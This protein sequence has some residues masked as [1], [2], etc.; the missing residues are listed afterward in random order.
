MQL[1]LTL[2][3]ETHD[4]RADN[5]PFLAKRGMLGLFGGVIAHQWTVD[6]SL[7][8]LKHAPSTLN[9]QQYLFASLYH[10]V[11]LWPREAPTPSYRLFCFRD[12]ENAF[13][14]FSGI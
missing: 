14:A 11:T 13:R 7:F 2:P 4:R 10:I 3:G 8:P 6:S 5:K 12:W 1:L 9:I